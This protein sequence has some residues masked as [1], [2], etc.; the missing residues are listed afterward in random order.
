MRPIV[1]AMLTLVVAGCGSQLEFADWTMPVPD[2]VP[3]VEHPFTAAEDRGETIGLI[4][5][6]VLGFDD[7]DPNQA[8]Y[9]L[10]DVDVDDDGNLWILD[11]GN[12]RVQVFDRDGGFI[13]SIGREGQGPGELESAGELAVVGD[14]LVVLAARLR[15]SSFDLDGNHLG[16]ST[17]EGIDGSLGYFFARDD[18]TLVSNYTAIERDALQ[19]GVSGDIPSTFHVV[20]L[21]LDGKVLREQATMDWTTYVIFSGDDQRPAPVSRPFPSFSASSRGDV[22]LTDASEYQ[23]YAFDPD[24]EAKWAMRV[25]YAA[26][27]LSEE[28]VQRALETAR[29]RQPE[30]TRGEL[31][32]PDRLPALSHIAVDGHGHVYVYPYFDR[33]EE[34]E[35]RPVDVYSPDGEL[36]FSGMILDRRWDNADGDYV[37]AAGSDRV[38]GELLVW[39]W[40]LDE[41]F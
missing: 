1:A 35:E 23:V 3:V 29:E 15:L 12:H 39:R 22:Y 5:D 17:L 30:V 21:S 8:F 33:G 28:I 14:R 16:D 4:E 9:S 13:R 26:P 7:S 25:A 34:L 19:L 38:T 36:L 11:G 32:W 40:R 41:P 20:T 2:G 10:R 24:G 6:L 31:M 37:F 18:G 27:E